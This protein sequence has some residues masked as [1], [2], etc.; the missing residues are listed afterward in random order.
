[1]RKSIFSILFAFSL[2]LAADC[3]V[4]A[5]SFHAFALGSH[6]VEGTSIEFTFPDEKYD[7]LYAFNFAV[8]E[9]LDSKTNQAIVRL[10]DGKKNLLDEGKSS[11][12]KNTKTG[13]NFGSVAFSK[14]HRGNVREVSYFTLTASPC[15]EGAKELSLKDN[16]DLK[17]LIEHA[18]AIAGALLK[19]M[20]IG[21][22][23]QA[24]ICVDR[25]NLKADITKANL[26]LKKHPELK[27][28][29]LLLSEVKY[30]HPQGGS[31]RHSLSMPVN[32]LAKFGSYLAQCK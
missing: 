31:E 4:Y 21:K 26:F 13:T 12:F 17:P 19:C 22:S 20:E 27:D 14:I 32:E 25:D 15:S 9:A 16:P 7:A 3:A 5:R 24:C 6:S 10:Y 8:W 11:C 2:M 30:P 29:E 28:K 18:S 1:M 23:E